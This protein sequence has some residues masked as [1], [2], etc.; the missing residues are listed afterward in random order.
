MLRHLVQRPTTLFETKVTLGGV[1][2]TV[3]PCMVHGEGRFRSCGATNESDMPTFDG[4]VH[5]ICRIA[6]RVLVV[7]WQR[8]FDVR[9]SRRL[10]FPVIP[11]V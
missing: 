11:P 1:T 8:S 10:H 4:S 6:A 5:G 9:G 7:G 2:H 3:C